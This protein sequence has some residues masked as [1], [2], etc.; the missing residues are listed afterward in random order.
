[1]ATSAEK[2]WPPTG[3][4]D[5]HQRGETMAIDNRDA[6]GMLAGWRWAY[7]LAPPGR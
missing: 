2:R 3:R 5:G 1:M 6:E 7:M 4:F